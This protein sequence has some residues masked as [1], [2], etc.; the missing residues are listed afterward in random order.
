MSHLVKIP[1]LS[2]V[3]GSMLPGHAYFFHGE[4]TVGKTVLGIQAARA[5]VQAGRTVLYLTG[6]RTSHFLEQALTL[7]LSL[8]SEWRDG[9]FILCKYA[10]SASRQLRDLGPEALLDRLDE[11]GRGALVSA[12]VFDPFDPLILQRRSRIELRNCLTGLVDG[13]C[14]REWSTLLLTGSKIL[15]RN[16]AAGEILRELCWAT[17]AMSRSEGT[18]RG[19]K[20]RAG[21]VPDGTFLLEIEKARQPIPAGPCVA[22]KIAYGTGL[23]PAPKSLSAGGEESLPDSAAQKPRVVLAAAEPDFFKPLAGLLQRTMETEIVTNGVDALSRAM[24][25]NPRVIVAETDLPRLSG[26]SV[27]RALRQGGYGMPVILISRATRRHSDR[28]R[29]YLNGATDFVFSPFDVRE[30]VYKVRVASQM[31]LDAFQDGVE[32]HMLEALLK[33]ARSHILGVPTFLEA[34]SLS[35][36]SGLRFSSPVSLVTLRLHPGSSEGRVQPFWKSL[37]RLLDKRARNGDLICFPDE[38]SV[39]ILLCHETRGGASAFVR[40]VRAMAE[41]EKVRCGPAAEGWR[42][43]I[44]TQTLHVS[45]QEE[46]DLGGFLNTAFDKPRIFIAADEPEEQ[47]GDEPDMDT[48]RWGT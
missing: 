45:E 18:P 9:R 11:V 17:L 38:R 28:V 34:L 26:F 46:V 2:K 1:F 20:H 12:V 22:Y 23:I 5:W 14:Q 32:E 27:S 8:E 33:K 42:I 47:A 6:D 36:C 10:D 19:R 35:L 31:R 16:P 43:E 40:R 4:P 39:A 24:T 25:W 13:F 7:G 48:K 21:S 30:M 41:R 37:K 44:S 29:A 15:Q 3:L